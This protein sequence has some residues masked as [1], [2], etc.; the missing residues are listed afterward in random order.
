MKIV[1]TLWTKP[2]F[3]KSGDLYNRLQGG[4]PTLKYALCAMVYSCLSIKKYYSNIELVTD[5]NGY[6]LLIENFG[7]PYSNINVSLNDFNADPN[8]W[9]LA[10]VY[11]Y[12]LQKEPFIHVDNDIFIWAKFP[13]RIENASLCSQNIET[14]TLDYQDGL[15]I[16]NT[17]IPAKKNIYNEY[18]DNTN[19]G[20]IYAVNAGILGGNDLDFINTYSKYV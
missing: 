6:K 8:L 1:Q 17:H 14:L 16:I 10:K 20:T 12:G 3:Q 9:A 11:S 7:L 13:D 15:N 5:S 4:W 19:F 2:M 18:S